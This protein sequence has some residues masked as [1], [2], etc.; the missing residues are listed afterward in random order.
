[1]RSEVN[2][3]DLYRFL[4]VQNADAWFSDSSGL[5]IYIYIC[6]H[7]ICARIPSLGAV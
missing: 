1:M 2:C 4:Q 5:C 6:I 3:E 7:Q